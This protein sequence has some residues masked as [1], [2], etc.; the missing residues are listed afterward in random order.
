MLQVEARRLVTGTQVVGGGACARV[1]AGTILRSS[2]MLTI[3]E[4]VL[5]A[6]A[7]R[8]LGYGKERKESRMT[9]R[10]S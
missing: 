7:E 8:L 4:T 3:P 10:P 9:L 6:F 2:Q 5:I 1:L